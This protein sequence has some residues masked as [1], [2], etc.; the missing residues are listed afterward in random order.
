MIS[1]NIHQN[2]RKK[3]EDLAPDWWDRDGQLKTLHD[4]NPLRLAR[5]HCGSVS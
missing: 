3:F 5:L 2:E 4:I 1:G